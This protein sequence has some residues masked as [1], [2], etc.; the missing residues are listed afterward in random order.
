MDTSMRIWLIDSGPVLKFNES[1]YH[2][3]QLFSRL[4]ENIFTLVVDPLF[5]PPL[6]L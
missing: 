5:P 6:D 2:E 4:V 1:S 3:K